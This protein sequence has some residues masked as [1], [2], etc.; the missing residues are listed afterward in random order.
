MS[1]E[2]DRGPFRKS[3]KGGILGYHRRDEK[4]APL[5]GRNPSLHRNTLEDPS[6]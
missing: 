3:T 6:F 5:R 2:R 1:P 4:I